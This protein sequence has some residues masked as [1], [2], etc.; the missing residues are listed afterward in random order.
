MKQEKKN[1]NFHDVDNL[2]G[3]LRFEVQLRN[4]DTT[5]LKKSG[6]INKNCVRDFLNPTLCKHFIIKNY[7]TL[8]GRGNYYSYYNA[9]SKCKSESQRTIIKLVYDE[10][11]IYQAKRN[12][13]ANSDNRRNAEKKF[14]E[15]I[16]KLQ[17]N[18]INPVTIESGV[19]KNLYSKI[20]YQIES[21]NQYQIRRRK[22]E[23]EE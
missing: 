15:I 6:L 13:L 9:L 14:S 2:Y 16:N 11:S 20:L 10:G 1:K 5:R 23:Y 17:S 4:V 19:V 18:G 7:D 21:S 12:F 8:I 3:V 22:I